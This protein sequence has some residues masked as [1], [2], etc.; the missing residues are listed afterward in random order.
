M[1]QFRIGDIVIANDSSNILYSLTT[2]KN[3][4]IGEVTE[5]HGSRIR[6]KPISWAINQSMNRDFNVD[7]KCFD[8]YKDNRHAIK[9]LRTRGE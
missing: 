7:S 3:N 9:M 6:V 4:F 8:F 1:N 5:S 2:K